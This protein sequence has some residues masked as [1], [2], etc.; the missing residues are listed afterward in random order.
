MPPRK[1]IIIK[2]HI[3]LKPINQ[4]SKWLSPQLTMDMAIKQ[5]GKKEKKTKNTD[6]RVVHVC[7]YLNCYLLVLSRC[8]VIFPFFFVS[9]PDIDNR[10]LKTKELGNHFLKSLRQQNYLE[11][12]SVGV[13][14]VSDRKGSE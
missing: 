11:V 7:M 2:N 5:N 13:V 1:K 4:I 14:G 9:C 6:N 12:H 8:C 10:Q 3:L